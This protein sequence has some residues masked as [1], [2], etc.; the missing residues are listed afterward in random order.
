MHT[1]VWKGQINFTLERFVAQHRHAFVSMQAAAE[2]DVYQLPNAY[3]RVGYLLDTIQCND[4]VL[5]ALI[6]NIKTN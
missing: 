3:I 2:H 1:R 4:A 6:S 5:Q